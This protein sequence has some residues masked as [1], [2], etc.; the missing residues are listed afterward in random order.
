MKRLHTE[1]TNCYGIRHLNQ[2]FDFNQ[3]L[4]SKRPTKAYAIYAPNGSMKSSFAKTFDQLARG[5]EPCEER[6]KRSS[7]WEVTADR[8][9]LPA[10]SIYVL[11]ADIDIKSEIPA[12]TNLLVKPDQKAR[13]DEL[14][15]DLEKKKQK[16]LS[17]LQKKSGVPKKNIEEHLLNVFDASD[18]IA[19][20]QIGLNR[21]IDPFLSAFNYKTI[22][23]ETALQIIQSEAFQKKAR[24]FNKRYDDLF[25]AENTIYSKGKFNPARAEAAFG[26]LKRERFFETGH[27]VQLRGVSEPLDGDQLELH[28]NAIHAS[29]DSDDTLRKIRTDLGGKAG[30][31]ALTDLIESL[32]NHQFDY[33]IEQTRPENEKQFKQNLWS[34]YLNEIQEAKAYRDEYIQISSEIERIEAEAKESVPAW[35]KAIKRFNRRFINMPFKLKI[36]NPKEAALGKETALLLFVFEESGE[37]PV[38]WTQRE[39][40]TLSQGERRA[41]Y[42]LGFILE[43]VAREQSGQETLFIC[44]DPADSF[45]YKNKHAIVQYLEDLTKVD[46]FY[47][48][49]LTHNFDLFR[50]LTRFVHRKRCL[51]AVRTPENGIRLQEF[52]GIENIFIKMWKPKVA[53]SDSI[54][55]ASIPFTRNLIEY[56]AG[57]DGEGFN[58]LS[59]LL[60]WKEETKDITVGEY[61]SIYNNLFGTK[62]QETDSRKMYD[63]L[64]SEAHSICE[65]NEHDEM[66][67]ENKVLISIA[68]RIKAE[69]FMTEELRRLKLDSSFWCSKNPP[70]GKLLEEY[71]ELEICPSKIELLEGVG[72]TVSSNI[73]LNSFMYEPILD[74]SIDHL[75][76]LYKRV[77]HL[78]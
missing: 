65:N 61:F 66:K 4:D 52:E 27:R 50:T 77:K 29:I 40:K 33:L 67:L 76:K 31:R 3:H 45:D 16:M 63:L 17:A 6:Y 24:E 19:A 47:Q 22:F 57:N 74:L 75:C 23:E 38:E 56:T 60:H 7:S 8:T 48:I 1:F 12:V 69:K 26:S 54:M 68:T 59:S 36:A 71:K 37:T 44:D 42:L 18:L 9:K 46:H 78:Q 41:M 15:I 25:E 49:I 20:I 34:Y 21:D 2:D 53:K 70:F 35:E 73:H 13:Y 11:K 58:K 5:R 64:I 55:L 43:V 62:N 32:D 10:E 72:I 14:I 51:S 30:P 28:V 39:V